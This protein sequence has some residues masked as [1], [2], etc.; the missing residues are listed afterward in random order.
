M[1]EVALGALE[2]AGDLSD[3]DVERGLEDA[4]VRVRRRAAELAASFPGDGPPSLLGSLDDPEPSVVEMA[5]WA[6][7]ERVPA[8]PGVVDRLASLATSHEE[9]LCREAAVAALGS[10]EQ[11]LG[12]VLVATKDRPAVR[13]RAVLALA[14]F[15]G[16]EVDKA[17]EA[18]RHDRDW[19]VRQAAADVAG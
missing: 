15:S 13:R 7:G 10:L 14:A 3:D 17:L 9:A 11:G 5:C 2:R 6:S 16:P 18:A 8:E 12:A 4:A 1:R 19:Q